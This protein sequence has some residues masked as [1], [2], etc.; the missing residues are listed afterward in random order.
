MGKI[1]VFEAFAGIGTQKMA[2]DR[3]KIDVEYVRISE[4]DKYAIKSY[5]IIHGS[6]IKNYG[7]ISKI[8]QQEL[9]S[10]DLFTYSFP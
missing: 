8:N 10:F 6:S 5:E 2:L 4:I 7:D 3:L 9:P 1:K